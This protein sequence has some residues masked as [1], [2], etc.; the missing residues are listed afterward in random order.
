MTN[1][2]AN[3]VS[4]VDVKDRKVVKTVSVGKGPN[5]ISVTP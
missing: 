2:Y 4:M 1:S 5:G 3:S